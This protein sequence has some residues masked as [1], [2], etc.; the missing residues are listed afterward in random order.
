M[1]PTVPFSSSLSASRPNTK[2]E[3]SGVIKGKL[4]KQHKLA[5]FIFFF[6][7]PFSDILEAQCICSHHY[8]RGR[9]V[10]VGDF[11]QF[12]PSSAHM[13]FTCIAHTDFC[14]AAPMIKYLVSSYYNTPCLCCFSEKQ[15]QWAI[16]QEE[17][18]FL[19]TVLDR[20]GD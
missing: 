14:I 9:A 18:K 13:Y 11:K 2:K 17:G 6:L 20:R 19:P 15:S 8:G 7:K 3:T 16:F 5:F 10:T 4:S 12:P 1:S